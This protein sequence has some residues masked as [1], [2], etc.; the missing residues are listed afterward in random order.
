MNMTVSYKYYYEYGRHLILWAFWLN[1][2]RIGKP[3]RLSPTAEVSQTLGQWLSCNKK[4]LR[5]T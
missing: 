4:R 3:T 5:R 2:R 1:V